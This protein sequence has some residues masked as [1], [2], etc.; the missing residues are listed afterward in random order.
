M[1]TAVIVT[2]K[3]HEDGATPIFMATAN[4]GKVYTLLDSPMVD[5][6]LDFEEEIISGLWGH[7]TPMTPNEALRFGANFGLWFSS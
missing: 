2:N 1:K 6:V 7:C 4:G 5:F 3:D